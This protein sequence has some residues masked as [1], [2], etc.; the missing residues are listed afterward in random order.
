M[1]C[2]E[3]RKEIEPIKFMTEWDFYSAG[4]TELYL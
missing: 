1:S 2:C 3:Y 4:T